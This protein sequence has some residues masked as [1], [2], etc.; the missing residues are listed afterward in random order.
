MKKTQKYYWK[1]VRINKNDP[2]TFTSSIIRS[3]KYALSYKIGIPTKSAMDENGIFVFNTRKNARAFKGNI[4]QFS[5]RIFKCT[6]QGKEILNP[7]YYNSYI[8]TNFDKKEPSTINTFPEGTKS[9]P[10]ITLVK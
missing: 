8:L 4:Y 6:V 2:T 10:A 3:G 5:G 9:F 7:V 1:L